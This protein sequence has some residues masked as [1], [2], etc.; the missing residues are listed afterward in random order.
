MYFHER[1][2]DYDQYDNYSVQKIDEICLVKFNDNNYVIL[3]L[4]Q[5][6]PLT[7]LKPN[8][9]FMKNVKLLRSDTL[10]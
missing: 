7:S 1:K 9:S 6:Y 3:G 8:Y 5:D 2:Y 10:V 4:F